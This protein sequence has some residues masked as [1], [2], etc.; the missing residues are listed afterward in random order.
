M[1]TDVAPSVKIID[2]APSAFNNVCVCSHDTTQL[3]KAPTLTL[4]TNT[5]SHNTNMNMNISQ[6]KAGAA[7]RHHQQ[8]KKKQAEAAAV[9]LAEAAPDNVEAV[10]ANEEGERLQNA[11]ETGMEDGMNDFLLMECKS[12][13]RSDTAKALL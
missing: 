11:N 13:A 8:K 9:A 6:H 5:T 3:N 12:N 4:P 1:A 7:T 10:N 2:A